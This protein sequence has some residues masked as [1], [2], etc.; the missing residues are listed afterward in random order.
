MTWDG[1]FSFVCLRGS[2][3]GT[4]R[5]LKGRGRGNFFPER[6]HNSTQLSLVNVHWCIRPSCPC[7]V[8]FV[9]QHEHGPGALLGRCRERGDY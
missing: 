9:E 6:I 8:A 2:V 7:L 3:K 4:G 1:G 5:G